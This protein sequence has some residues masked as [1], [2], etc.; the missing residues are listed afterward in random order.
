MNIG[1]QLL[2]LAFVT[3]SVACSNDEGGEAPLNASTPPMQPG[4]NVNIDDP[5]LVALD[6][7][8]VSPGEAMKLVWSEEF[9]ADALDPET[10]FFD[11]GDGS[12]YGIPGWGNNELQWYLPDNAQLEDGKLVITIR[13]EPTNGKDYSSA[14]IDT[15]DR[16]AVRYGRIEARIRLP[17][18]QGLWPAFWMLPLENTYGTWAA[19][20]EID[21]MESVNPGAEGGNIIHG[22]IHHGA[23]HPANQYAGAEYHV[24]ADPTENFHVYAVEWD[25]TEIRWYVDD[26]LY[27]TQNEWSTTDAEYPAPFDQPFYLLLNVAVGGDWPGLDVDSASLPATMEVDYIRV[28]SGETGNS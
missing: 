9:D 22:T 24:P 1:K 17:K 10:W 28:Y 13:N 19:S 20:G 25:P 16:F 27:S 5:T 21:I 23:R 18:G 14:R 7:S 6:N 12:Q 26:V 11:H 8:P 15:R 3:T 2:L 4:E